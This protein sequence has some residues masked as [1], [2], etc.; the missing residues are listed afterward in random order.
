MNSFNKRKDKIFFEKLAKHPDVHGFLIANLSDNEKLW[1]RELAYSEKAEQAYKLWMKRQ[2]SLTYCFKQDLDKLHNDFN[3]NFLIEENSHPILLKKYLGDEICLETLC[4]LLNL[5][6]G[7]MKHWDTKLS[8]DLVWDMLG[9][10]VRKYT[11]FVK[12]DREKYKQI[13]LDHFN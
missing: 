4:I 3:K 10:K 13:C 8:Y 6:P 7:A 12:F 2:Q 11:P 9:T 1:I 5:V